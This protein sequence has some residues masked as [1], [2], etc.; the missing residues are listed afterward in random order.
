[1]LNWLEN[2]WVIGIWALRTALTFPAPYLFLGKISRKIL[3]KCLSDQSL[4]FSLTIS[5]ATVTPA[6]KLKPRLANA[7]C[8][9]N[10]VSITAFAPTE[11]GTGASLLP[12]QLKFK[13]GP[14]SPLFPL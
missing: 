7:N 14:H 2:F 11:E 1:M 12:L 4:P 8:Q 9:S 10:P 13:G 5:I 3:S 6:P